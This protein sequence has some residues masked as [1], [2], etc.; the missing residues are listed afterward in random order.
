[1]S[2][3]VPVEL[4]KSWLLMNHGP[5][6]LVTSSCDGVGNVMAAS[7]AMP[8]DYDPPKVIV[9]LDFD[10]LTCQNIEKSGEFGL[11]LPVGAQADMTY[12]VGSVS[13][14]EVNKFE[15]YKIKTFAAQKI[16]VPMIEGCAAWME[17]KLLPDDCQK[18]GIF[19][20]EVVAAYTDSEIFSDGRWHFPADPMHRTIHHTARGNFYATGELI[21]ANVD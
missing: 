15:K 6:T 12:A 14:R 16:S 4:A 11:Q 18:H 17:C 1:M 3:K 10:A 20:A 9:V 8:L 19:I 2:Q 7:W 21:K 5:T 13:G